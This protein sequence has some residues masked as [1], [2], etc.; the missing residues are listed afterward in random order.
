[1]NGKYVTIGVGELGVDMGRED[2]VVL[3]MVVVV[4]LGGGDD[5]ALDPL[6]HAAADAAGDD[7]ADGEA[8]VGE[9]R[10]AILHVGEHDVP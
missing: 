9:Q 1:M 3:V 10:L 2:A 4:G 7:G 8:V 5:D 6:D